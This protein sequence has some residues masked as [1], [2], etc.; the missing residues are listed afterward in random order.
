MWDVKIVNHAAIKEAVANITQGTAE[1][2][3][4]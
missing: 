1:D 3:A 4:E 2:E